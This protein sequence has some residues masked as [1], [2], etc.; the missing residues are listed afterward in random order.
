MGQKYKP[1]SSN[2]I[3]FQLFSPYFKTF[4][5]GVIV[6]NCV[7]PNNLPL[8]I[9]IFLRRYNNYGKEKIKKFG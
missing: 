6:E 7:M 2:P 1:I 9:F 4:I 8:H 3:A 5:K